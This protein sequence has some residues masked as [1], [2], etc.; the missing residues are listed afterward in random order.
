MEFDTAKTLFAVGL[1]LLII[2]YP[3]LIFSPSIILLV[4]VIV[5]WIL[6]LEGA[7]GLS[8]HYRRPELFRNMLY[9]VIIAIIGS[10][11]V[12]AVVITAYISMSASPGPPRGLGGVTSLILIFAPLWA[13]GVV[14]AYFVKRVYRGLYEVSK[15]DSFKTAATLVWIGALT[16]IIL[17]GGAIY[18]VGQIF[19][20][21]G[22]FGLKPPKPENP[23]Q[24]Q[25]TTPH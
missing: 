2:T 5:S 16:A 20:I 12:L 11:I 14:V 4:I 1:I 6:I 13:L 25:D 9:A 24:T 23:P 18:L 15:V 21:V 8:K 22:A 7:D 10:V 19:A 17:V 3:L